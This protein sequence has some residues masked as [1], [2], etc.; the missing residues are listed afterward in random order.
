MGENDST[1]ITISKKKN[2]GS[3]DLISPLVEIVKSVEYKYYAFMFLLFMFITSDVFMERVLSQ[4]DG[5]LEYQVPTP[6]GSIIQGIALI[7]AMLIIHIMI[8]KEII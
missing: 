3:D 2:K 1:K 6:Y 5:A 8:T 4:I 7:G